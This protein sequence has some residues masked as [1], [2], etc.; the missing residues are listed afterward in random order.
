MEPRLV[1]LRRY[2]HVLDA[3]LP[4]PGTRLRIGLDPILGLVPGLGDAAGAFLAGWILVE[5]VRLD[6]APATLGRMTA[7]LALDA[8]LGAIPIL[9]DAFD[10]VWQA[11]LKNVA[12]LEPHAA[13]P[14]RAGTADTRFVVLLAAGVV[15]L[16]GALAAG[17]LLVG[18]WLVK[19]VAGS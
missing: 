18:A 8:A 16:C 10:G 17:G 1:R 13:D 6:V 5:A 19:L 7:N 12:L 9:G 3:G 11:N 14:A 4:V 15:V 2:A